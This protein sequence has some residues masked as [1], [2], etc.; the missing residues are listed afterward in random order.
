MKENRIEKRN[1]LCPFCFE[2]N[3]DL[4]FDGIDIPVFSELDIVGGGYRSCKC[5]TCGSNDRERLVYIYLV[6]VLSVFKR[7]EIK[8]LHVAPEKNVYKMLRQQFSEEE[9]MAGALYKR[10]YRF[11]KGFIEFDLTDS[12]FESNIFDLVICNHVLEH[13][14]EDI[15]ALKEIKRIMKPTGQAILQVPIA[16]KLEQT[17]EREEY[18]SD[19]DRLKYY[20]QKD[21][22][23][24]YGQDYV[25]RLEKAGFKVSKYDLY[26]EYPRYGLNEK[27]ILYTVTLK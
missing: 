9:Y 6:D 25:D 5:P 10:E 23:R 12:A 8:I 20:G 7:S 13:I 3:L 19:Q 11:V 2:E 4:L 27:E 1:T 15:I 26:K 21:H 24:V 18:H 22:V 16:R 17:L 14:I